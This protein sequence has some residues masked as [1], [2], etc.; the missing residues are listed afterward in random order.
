MTFQI[1]P[2]WN[3]PWH[4]AASLHHPQHS[5]VNVFIQFRTKIRLEKK[6]IKEKKI[7]VDEK[8]TLAAMGKLSH[9]QED[10]L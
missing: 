9:N 6:K 10:L 1:V 7:K 4:F 3:Q 2:Q 8:P 5:R